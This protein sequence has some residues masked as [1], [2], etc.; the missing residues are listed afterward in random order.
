MTPE[1]ALQ[2][3]ESLRLKTTASGE[4]NDQIRQAVE[5]I[6]AALAESPETVAPRP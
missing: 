5:T 3:L 1:Q 4:L 6:R 2:I